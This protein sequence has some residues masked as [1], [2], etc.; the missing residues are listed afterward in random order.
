M[1]PTLLG[2][3]VGDTAVVQTY[4]KG[5]NQPSVGDVYYVSYDYQKQDFS[6][7]L[8]TKQSAVAATYGAQPVPNNP[9]SL[10]WVSGHPQRRSGRRYQAG[11]E[12]SLTLTAD[13]V[14]G[15]GQRR[16]P[17]SPLSTR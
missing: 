7:A 16:M 5:G 2:S 17:T 11:K 1:S 10:G 13:G 4:E 14:D 6:P 12:G 3:T 15:Y 9:V 8:F